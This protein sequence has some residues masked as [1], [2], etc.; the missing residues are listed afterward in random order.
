MS[1]QR[2]DCKSRTV[3]GL[4]HVAIRV[5]SIP[6]SVRYY[7]DVLGLREAFRMFRED[8]SAATVY[9]YLAPGQYLELF[10]DGAREGITGPDVIGMC[11]LCL[12][13]KDIRGSH[14][15]VKAAGGPLDSEITRGKSQCRMFWT[16]DPDGTQ[17][18]VMEMP[19]ESLQAQADRRFEKDGR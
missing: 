10:A 1:S 19:P 7:T 11:H 12:M 5:R 14:S 9:M 16:H 8:G 6:D 13:T 18:E 3:E 4:S 2:D 17:I 15:A